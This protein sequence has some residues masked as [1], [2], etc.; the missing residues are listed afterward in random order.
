MI[1]FYLQDI[2]HE[3]FEP[4]IHLLVHQIQQNVLYRQDHLLLRAKIQNLSKQ[5][6]IDQR[7]GTVIFKEVIQMISMYSMLHLLTSW[8]YPTVCS[9]LAWSLSSFN[10]SYFSFCPLK[11]NNWRQ[12]DH[13]K[14]YDVCRNKFLQLSISLHIAERIM[15]SSIIIRRWARTYGFYQRLSFIHADCVLRLLFSFESE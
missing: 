1:R 8:K 13:L 14:Y 7:I 4:Q 9:V 3:T 10:F 12:L 15:S 11:A 5:Y 6:L 2:V